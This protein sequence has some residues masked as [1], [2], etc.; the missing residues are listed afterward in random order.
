[1][2]DQTL[3]CGGEKH[4]NIPRNAHDD[5]DDSM[6]SILISFLEERSIPIVL[7]FT[8]C[9]LL[10]VR[11]QGLT[12]LSGSTVNYKRTVL[13]TLSRLWCVC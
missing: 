11:V 6:G 2:E 1:M 10:I 9:L 7:A 13:L 3:P 12:T 8:N 4:L 5:D